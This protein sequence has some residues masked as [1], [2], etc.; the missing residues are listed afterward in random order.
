MQESATNVTS[1]FQSWLSEFYPELLED[2]YLAKRLDQTWDTRHESHL[3]ASEELRRSNEELRR[4]DERHKRL[5][6]AFYEFYKECPWGGEDDNCFSGSHPWWD[7]NGFWWR[8]RE[9]GAVARE[10]HIPANELSYYFDHCFNSRGGVDALEF[11][12]MEF[13]AP[14]DGFVE[15]L[16]CELYF[17]LMDPYSCIEF[18]D[19]PFAY[20]NDKMFDSDGE[21]LKYD[22]EW[23][24]QHTVLLFADFCGLDYYLS[25]GT[26]LG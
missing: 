14:V 11:P 10:S 16:I 23:E 12:L 1:N 3:S 20:L 6:S 25:S 26:P 18:M 24:L 9:E 15:E 19:F 8:D 22:F 21:F 13:V 7:R 2:Y 4:R 17:S 5:V